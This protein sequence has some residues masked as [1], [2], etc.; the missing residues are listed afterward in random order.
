MDVTKCS[1][2]LFKGKAEVV[3][4]YLVS[5]LRFVKK[6]KSCHFFFLSILFVLFPGDGQLQQNGLQ[7]V[8][9]VF[10][11]SYQFLNVLL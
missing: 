9:V 7:L 4:A 11:G 5:C 10:Q 2:T 3:D 6:I 8:K 1:I